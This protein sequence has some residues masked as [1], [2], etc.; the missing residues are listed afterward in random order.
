MTRPG[1][2]V[3][4][5]E[6]GSTRAWRRR[7]LAVL[8]RDAW[9]CQ[10]PVDELGR[11]DPGGRPCHRPAD[12][13]DHVVP[14]ALGGDDDPANLRAACTPHNL[15]KGGRLDGAQGPARAPRQA[16]TRSWGW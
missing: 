9:R 5:A 13:V 14:R 10:V 1:P 7:R 4:L 16:P 6:G 11:I 8:T 15:S 2:L 3:G 12:T